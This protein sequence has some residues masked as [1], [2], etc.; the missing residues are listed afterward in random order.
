MF[1]I[2]L[3][4]ILFNFVFINCNHVET[5]IPQQTLGSNKCTWGPAYWCASQENANECNFD[6]DECLKFITPTSI[7][8]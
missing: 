5:F 4:I 2:I 8:T 3:A 7:L 1:F 6:F